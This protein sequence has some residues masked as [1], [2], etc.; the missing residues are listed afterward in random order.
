MRV[1]TPMKRASAM[2]V[3]VSASLFRR[4]PAEL[5]WD[6]LMRVVSDAIIFLGARYILSGTTATFAKTPSL[7]LCFECT[8]GV[9]ALSPEACL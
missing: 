4:D 1:D 7:H 5:R 9:R 6:T 2:G 8:I 3:Q